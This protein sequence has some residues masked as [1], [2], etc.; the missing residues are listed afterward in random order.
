ME[1][2]EG[3]AGAGRARSSFNAVPIT[4][5]IMGLSSAVLDLQRPP[6]NAAEGL[7]SSLHACVCACMCACVPSILI[8]A[9]SDRSTE[10][11]DGPSGWKLLFVKM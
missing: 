8:S 10:C 1:V 11:E 9:G 5:F 7:A 3:R 4:A 2:V 6:C